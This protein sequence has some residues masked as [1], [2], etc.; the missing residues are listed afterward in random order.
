MYHRE[1]VVVCES[2]L[3]VAAVLKLHRGGSSF[4]SFISFRAPFRAEFG[5][6]TAAAAA[7]CA[8]VELIKLGWKGMVNAVRCGTVQY[9]AMQCSTMQYSTV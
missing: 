4:I 8:A 7:L 5:T 3:S 9:S 6:P 1:L 2:G